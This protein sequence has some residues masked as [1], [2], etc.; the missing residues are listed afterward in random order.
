MLLIEPLWNWNKKIAFALILH[1]SLLIEPLW[2]WN[3]YI[4][5]YLHIKAINF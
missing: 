2:N 5:P 1:D 3:L 4:L